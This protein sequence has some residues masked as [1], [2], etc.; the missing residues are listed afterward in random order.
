MENKDLFS[1]ENVWS[2]E[3]H[4]EARRHL[5]E[6]Y[7]F[8]GPAPSSL[9]QASLQ[10]SQIDWPQPEANL[11]G[12]LCRNPAEFFGGPFYDEAGTL[13]QPAQGLEFADL[14][15][16]GASCIM[17]TSMETVPCKVLSPL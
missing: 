4:Y 3:G 1:K 10:Q 16:K 13:S 7:T 9:V 8:L 2:P 15:G 11:D 6:M 17:N 5:A 14:S 12:I